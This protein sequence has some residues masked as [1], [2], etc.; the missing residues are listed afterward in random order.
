DYKPLA[1]VTGHIHESIG[2]DKIGDTTVINP[3]SLAD[4]YYAWLS[5][6]HSQDRWEVKQV[7][8]KRV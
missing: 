5:I 3:G 6:A 8:L 1:V 2:Y 4:G 7:E